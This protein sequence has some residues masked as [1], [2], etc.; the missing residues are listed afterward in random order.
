M[1]EKSIWRIGIDIGQKVDH[2]AVCV[3]EEAGEKIVVRFIWKYPLGF[4]F[5]ELADTI[6]DLYHGVAGKGQVYSLVVDATG[7]GSSPAT[8][9]QQRLPDMRVD[10]FIFT[11]KS[12][13]ELVGKVNVLHATGR[14]RFARKAKDDTAYNHMLAELINEMK[15]VQTKVIRED[16]ANPEIEVFSTGAHDDLFTALALAI[17]DIDLR[18]STQSPAVVMMKDDS[19]VKTPLDQRGNE[20]PVAFF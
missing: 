5:P 3:V 12:K 20:P 2:S 18:G 11:N 16:E 15:S 9:I 19:W 14:L 13:R 1:S 6:A 7:I 8:M 17:K 10:F 4:P